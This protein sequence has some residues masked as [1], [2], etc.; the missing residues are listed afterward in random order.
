MARRRLGLGAFVLIALAGILGSACD[1][2]G[3]GGAA[4]ST[5]AP[6][7]TAPGRAGGS[8]ANNGRGTADTGAEQPQSDVG[9]TLDV[10][11]P[12]V[13]PKVVKTASL[14]LQVREVTFQR[15]FQQAVL[16]A[17]RHAGFVASSETSSGSRPSGTL[18]LRVPVEEFEAALGE[19]KALGK[20]TG[21]K[22]SGEDVTSQFIDLEARERNWEAQESVL[23]RLMDKTST[24]DESIKVQRS[25]QDVQGAIEQVRGQLRVLTDQTAFS[26]I[27][28]SMVEAGAPKAAPKPNAPKGT[29]ARAW[30]HAR[31]GFLSVIAA[32][33]IGLGYILPFAVLVLVPALVW[34]AVIRRTRARATPP[35]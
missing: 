16:V 6:M 11:I 19:L 30:D 13:G 22:V 24:I 34:L 29:L 14:S 2:G 5:P 4:G 28:A 17:G 18:T 9:V 23:L 31:D 8:G 32:V 21:Q 15:A 26:T 27:T 35:A 10:S 3:G 25:L 20:V 12:T 1:S 33:V 7:A